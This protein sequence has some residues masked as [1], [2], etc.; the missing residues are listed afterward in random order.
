[1]KTFRSCIFVIITGIFISVSAY[2]EIMDR[3]VAIVNGDS[4]T[5]S[6]LNGTFEP[7]RKKIDEAYKGTDK[8]KIIASNRMLLLKKMIDNILIDQEAKKSG[9]TV[10]DNEVTEMINDMLSRRK[11]KMED[12]Q[13]ELAKEH[14][15]MEAYRKEI[16]EHLLRMRLLKREVRSKITVS[17]E[18]IGDYYLKHREAYEGKEAVRIKQILI[19][20]PNNPDEKIKVNLRKQIDA[21]HKRLLNGEPFEQLAVQYSQGPGAVA[22]GD[23][24]FIEKGTILPSVETVAF[25]LKMDEISEVIES[26]V[27][28]HIIK[29][30]DKRGAGIKPI[31]SV[32]DEIKAKIEEEKSDKKYDEWIQ[33]LRN[34]SLIEIKI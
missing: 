20:Y 24:G 32:R 5:L 8:E 13:S 12:L 10:T 2:G 34:K 33:E 14:S 19:L 17:E 31:N 3:I 22:G 15:T 18:E 21:I 26:P 27:G 6:E 7:Y 9:I 4:I 23:I 25:R 16:K 30:I 11:I 1:M 28:F 29:A